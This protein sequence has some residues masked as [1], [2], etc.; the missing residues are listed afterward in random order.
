MP[1]KAKPAVKKASAKKNKKP[2]KVAPKVSL[3]GLSAEMKKL[4]SRIKALEDRK[5][6]AGPA[7]PPG[8]VGPQ[9]PKGDPADTA[10]LDALEHR[11]GELETKL[12]SQGTAA[13]V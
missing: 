9:G 4:N 2:Q 10:R 3:Q 13:V 12:A 1:T 5:P 6:A 7:G 11:I 8:E